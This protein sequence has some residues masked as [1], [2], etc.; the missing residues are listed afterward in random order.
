[1]IGVEITEYEGACMAID[2]R[3]RGRRSAAVDTHRNRPRLAVLDFDADGVDTA[4]RFGA[5]L[6]QGITDDANAASTARCSAGGSK[7]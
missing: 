2:H 6:I 7:V 1:M 4:C 5:T 3:W